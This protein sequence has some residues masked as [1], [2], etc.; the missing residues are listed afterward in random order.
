MSY[1]EVRE[2]G[3]KEDTGKNSPEYS[4]LDTVCDETGFRV[5]RDH[6]YLHPWP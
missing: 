4:N 2:G 3:S 1:L 6:H 5:M